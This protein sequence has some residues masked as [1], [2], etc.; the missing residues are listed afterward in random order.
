M[1]PLDV[2]YKEFHDYISNER[3]FQNEIALK[4]KVYA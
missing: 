2:L 1:N 4:V 3:D